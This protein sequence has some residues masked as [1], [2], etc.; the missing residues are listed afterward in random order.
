MSSTTTPA[1]TPSLSPPAGGVKL[2]SI[3]LAPPLPPPGSRILVGV[4]GGADSVALLRLLHALAPQRGWSIIAA[5]INHGLRPEADQDQQFVEELAH[6]LGVEVGVER[7]VVDGR[8]SP[9]ARARQG[10]L[11]A[12]EAMAQSF[13][14]DFIALAHTADDQAETLL[15]RVLE[16]SGPTG[17]AGMRVLSGRLWRP[18]LYTRRAEL[19]AYLKALGQPWREDPSNASLAF[20]R[21][22]IRHRLLP[23]A[24]QLINPR[25]VEAL[26]RLGQICAVEEEFWDQWCGQWLAAHARAEGPSMVLEAPALA[27]LHPAQQLRVVRAGAGRLVGRGQH[28]LMHHAWQVIELLD[29]SPGKYLN[30]GAGLE[31]WRETRALRIAL[32]SAPGPVTA[33]LQGPGAVDVGEGARVVVQIVE[34]QGP[35]P[36]RGEEGWVRAEA[37]EWPLVVRRPPAPGRIR[38][39][40][41]PGSKPMAK[42]LKDLGVPR[43]WRKRVVVVE[44]QGG[45]VWV[46][47]VGVA[48]R[49]RAEKGPGSWVVIRWEWKGLDNNSQL[50]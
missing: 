7:L 19:R 18:L 46:G 49:M 9:E 21:N 31:A 25:A 12:L 22:R 48:E 4:S 42:L 41:M 5:H 20:T 26:V 34:G 10:R 16:G 37:V 30:L 13:S 35:G 50:G 23:L 43:W 17:L 1:P 24:Q 32:K 6:A 29:K 8:G 38:L 40:G 47:P 44:D 2:G 39:L 11:K 33:M 14:A 3:V 28:L 27:R 45:V 15:M 36:A